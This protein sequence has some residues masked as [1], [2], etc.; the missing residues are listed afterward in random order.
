MNANG[1]HRLLLPAILLSVM[2]VAGCEKRPP[3]PTKPR[4]DAIAPANAQPAVPS[5]PDPSVPAASSVL[6]A[7]PPATTAKDEASKKVGSN[8]NLTRSEE[9]TAMPMPGQVNNHSTP[10]LDP[11][12]TGRP[13]SAP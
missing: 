8:D 12:N 3:D 4:T 1:F 6:S 13:A 5:A 10:S 11:A 2:A 9:S 7:P